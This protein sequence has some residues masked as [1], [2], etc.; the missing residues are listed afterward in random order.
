MNIGILGSGFGIYGYLPAA[1]LNG[2]TVVT[3]ARYKPKIES[4]LELEMF[5]PRVKY[6]SDEDSLMDVA[7]SLII[8]RDPQSQFKALIPA[9]G[10]FDH[11]YLEKPLGVNPLA[12]SFLLQQLST[13]KQ[14][15]SIGY[16]VPFTD[17]FDD[18][19]F[20]KSIDAT[21]SWRVNVD[22][23][24]WKAN[25]FPDSG[26]FT[27]FGVHFLP[28][29]EKF[30]T[31][32]L[33]LVTSSRKDRIEISCAGNN[34]SLKVVLLSG[35]NPGFELTT[36]QEERMTMSTINLE[37]PFGDKSKKGIPDNRI[38]LLQKYLGKNRLVSDQDLCFKYE[39]LFLELQTMIH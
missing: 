2:D 5:L 37:T 19:D 34:G 30:A 27:Y 39:E 9:L 36:Q 23:Q 12:H 3:L 18:L 13:K 21:I 24:S 11:I 35:G 20:K 25:S 4:R 6:V 22:N 32:S 28:L 1:I 17:W 33:S 31:N 14:S 38:P 15:F 26:L 7:D 29:I 16:L 8:A 10:R